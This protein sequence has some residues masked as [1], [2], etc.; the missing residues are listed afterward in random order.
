M[1]K[2]IMNMAKEESTNNNISEKIL[3]EFQNFLD[4]KT[5]EE[6]DTYMESL[7]IEYKLPEILILNEEEI[8]YL[9]MCDNWCENHLYN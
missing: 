7:D 6:L 5:P 9:N 1:N 2:D 8:K 3:D 4:S